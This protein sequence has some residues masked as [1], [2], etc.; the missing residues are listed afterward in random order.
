MLFQTEKTQ[1]TLQGLDG[2]NINETKNNKM[3]CRSFSRLVKTQRRF[4]AT[5]PKKK[6]IPLFMLHKQNAK[7]EEIKSQN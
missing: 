6:A 2:K 1:E 7:K 3:F 4:Y 5:L